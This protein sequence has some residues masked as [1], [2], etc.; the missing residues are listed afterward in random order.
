MQNRAAGATTGSVLRESH[1]AVCDWALR[2][3]TGKGKEET[4]LIPAFKQ[5]LQS[6]NMTTLNALTVETSNPVMSPSIS[7]HQ[8]V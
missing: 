3:H 7:V 6:T 1:F 2:G 8:S 4:S 5:L